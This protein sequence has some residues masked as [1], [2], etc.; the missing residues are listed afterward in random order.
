MSDRCLICYR[1]LTD[2][3]VHY[4][5]ACSKRFF[6]SATAPELPYTENEMR[7]LALQ[8][9]RSQRIVTGVQ[10][11][12]SLDLPRGT[13]NGAPRRFTIVGLWG[14]YILKPPAD[15]YPFMPETEDL[16]MHLAEAAGIAVV[17]HAL[18]PLR[19]GALAYITKRIDRSPH[20]KI[21]MEDLCQLTGKLTEQKYDG[22][23]EQVA[24]TVRRYSALPGLDVMNLFEIVLFSFLTGN[25]D[26]HLKNFSLIDR[27]GDGMVLAPAY[28]LLATALVNPSDTE[29]TALT[30]NG[31]KKNIRRKDFTAAFTAAGLTDRQQQTLLTKFGSFLPVWDDLIEGSFLDAERKEAYRALIRARWARLVG[32]QD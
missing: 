22:S 20:G 14:S 11:K 24:R 7:G 1:P 27:P 4:H 9:I 19:S 18:I 30:L 25:A 3:E 26:M 6:G 31:R 29:E 10:P 23:Y 17:P 12:L 2:G 28:D 8:T 32:E 13:K 16:T 5:A 15:A 21:A